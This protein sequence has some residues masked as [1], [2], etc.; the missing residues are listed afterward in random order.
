MKSSGYYLTNNITNQI[1]TN[2]ATENEKK[3]YEKLKVMNINFG[4]FEWNGEHFIVFKFK[5][6]KKEFDSLLHLFL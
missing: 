6:I 5:D 4:N 2:M 3:L 1:T